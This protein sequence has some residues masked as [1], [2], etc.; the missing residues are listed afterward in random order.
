MSQY[1]GFNS[2]YVDELIQS[3]PAEEFEAPKSHVKDSECL[4]IDFDGSLK[5][6]AKKL[7]FVKVEDNPN[8]TEIT[9]EQW[10]EMNES[11]RREFTIKD[12][13]QALHDS[14]EHSYDRIQVIER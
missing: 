12:L 13:G 14:V 5:I 2:H 1:I 3:L 4:I 8:A 7:I 6:S 10:L 9:G 11:N